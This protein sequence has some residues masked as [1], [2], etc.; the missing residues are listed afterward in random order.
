MSDSRSYN[1]PLIHLMPCSLTLF[2]NDQYSVTTAPES[3]K[4]LEE[5]LL[6]YGLQLCQ[7]PEGFQ[8]G[9][10]FFFALLSGITTLLSDLKEKSSDEYSEV[11]NY[12]SCL[13]I[14]VKPENVQNDIKCLRMKLSDELLDNAAVYQSLLVSSYINFTEEA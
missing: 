11:L 13:E 3:R 12:L 5:V 4:S 7:H 2:S 10:S 9:E 1:S 14:I 8:T 6:E